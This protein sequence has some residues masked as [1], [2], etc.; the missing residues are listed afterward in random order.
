MRDGEEKEEKK[1]RGKRG[2]EK[3]RKRKERRKRVI[4]FI[5]RLRDTDD[6][7][8]KQH[9]SVDAGAV[10]GIQSAAPCLFAVFF[11]SRFG[12]C[13][14]DARAR[15]AGQAGVRNGRS[16]DEEACDWREQSGG[17]L[18]RHRC[19]VVWRGAR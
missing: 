12:H 5:C 8:D 2:K 6:K 16:R 14:A 11:A 15:K 10:E 17:R 13:G 1:K 19:A 4:C 7:T 3:G 18:W 9:A